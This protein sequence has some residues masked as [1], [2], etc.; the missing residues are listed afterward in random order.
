M[1]HHC[2]AQNTHNEIRQWFWWAE[3]RLRKASALKSKAQSFPNSPA[4]HAIVLS[5]SCWSA[6]ALRF[7][8]VS[9]EKAATLQRQMQRENNGK[10]CYLGVAGCSDEENE[11]PSVMTAARA[12]PI[13]ADTSMAFA[14]R[15]AD[16]PSSRRS[17]VSWLLHKTS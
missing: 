14:R 12:S 7:F 13:D 1:Q 9:A 10:L 2:E 16:L 3:D 11:Y 5:F 6:R 17:W 15:C 4:S 8:S